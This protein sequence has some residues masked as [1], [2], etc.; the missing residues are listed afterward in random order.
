MRPQPHDV[1]RQGHPRTGA[2]TLKK[3]LTS[4][5]ASPSPKAS[6]T[7]PAP[8]KTPSEP[9]PGAHF[10]EFF[11]GRES[12]EFRYVFPLHEASRGR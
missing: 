1:N 6:R 11:P 5:S 7:S 9:T 2:A 12:Q 3:L 4:S 10:A 8:S